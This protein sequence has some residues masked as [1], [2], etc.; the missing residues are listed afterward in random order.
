[1]RAFSLASPVT[2]RDARLYRV[3]PRPVRHA[4]ARLLS[5]HL[6]LH[7][8]VTPGHPAPRPARLGRRSQV[9][10]PFAA[11]GRVPAGDT[12]GRAPACTRIPGELIPSAR[13]GTG[14]YA[15]IPAGADDGR[16]IARPRPRR[17]AKPPPACAGWPPGAP[18]PRT[19]VVAAASSSPAP[20]SIRPGCDRHLI[21]RASPWPRSGMRAGRTVQRCP[22]MDLPPACG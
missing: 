16:L 5:G 18:T 8:I 12:R 3:W 6:R 1:M 2:D 11:A 15:D 21:S 19:C 13:H 7:G 20:P 9:L 10:Q 17:G 22:F 4:L 14:R